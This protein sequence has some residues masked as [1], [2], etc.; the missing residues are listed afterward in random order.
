MPNAD[1]SLPV[2]PQLQPQL[3]LQRGPITR[4]RGIAVAGLLAATVTTTGCYSP[5][6]GALPSS[7]G[8]WTYASTESIGKTFTL[9]DVRSGEPVFV[10]VVPPGEQ[11]T[12]RFLEGLGDD[13]VAT[14]DR[15]IYELQPIGTSS[16]RLRNQITVPPAGARRIDIDVTQD[17]RFRDRPLE[18]RYR[19]DA[20]E[21]RPDWWSPVG[22]PIPAERMRQPYDD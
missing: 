10:Q 5:K 6:G 9:V 2:Q 17:I 1:P 11:L 20:P 12:V 3:Q 14:P 21:D 4:M 8:A 19:V 7:T 15:M 22:G 16:G 18:E 13:P